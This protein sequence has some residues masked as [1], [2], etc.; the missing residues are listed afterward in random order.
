MSLLFSLKTTRIL[1]GFCFAVPFMVALTPVQP[2]FAATPAQIEQLKNEITPSVMNSLAGSPDT[3][4]ATLAAVVGRAR[5]QGFTSDEIDTGIGEA[6]GLLVDAAKLFDAQGAG[7][8]L[9][10]YP[11][12]SGPLNQMSGGNPASLTAATFDAQ[13]SGMLTA[14]AANMTNPTAA[15]ALLAVANLVASG[16]AASI[17]GAAFGAVPAALVQNPASNS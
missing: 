16:Q 15:A 9:A 11:Q 7:G 17:S 5:G 8:L 6:A 3:L 10:V 4:N 13:I 14:M 12:L 2:G 1:K